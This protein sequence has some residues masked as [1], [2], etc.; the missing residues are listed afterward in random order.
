MKSFLKNCP[1]H[2]HAHFSILQEGMIESQGII[3]KR[4]NKRIR[5]KSIVIEYYKCYN[6]YTRTKHCGPCKFSG[7]LIY[8]LNSKPDNLEIL[9]RH[10]LFCINNEGNKQYISKSKTKYL[11]KLKKQ[12]IKVI[13]FEHNVYSESIPIVN[14]TV[15]VHSE[16]SSIEL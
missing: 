3:L 8:Q 11:K 4:L 13:P 14:I 2:E 15:Q 16:D 12:R 7:K 1:H 6:S 10:S 9:K 5:N